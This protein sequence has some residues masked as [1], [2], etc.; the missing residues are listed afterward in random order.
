MD[1]NPEKN[2]PDPQHW[3]KGHSF[4]NFFLPGMRQ[5]E[6]VKL[7]LLGYEVDKLYCCDR[8]K[9]GGRRVGVTVLDTVSF[10]YIV[11]IIPQ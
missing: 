2:G 6:C 11:Y 10:F 1:P 5:V 3:F 4:M 7:A 9:V 8:G